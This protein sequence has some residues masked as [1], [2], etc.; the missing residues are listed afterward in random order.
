MSY[1]LLVSVA[2]AE[3]RLRIAKHILDE[4]SRKLH[5]AERELLAY[6]RS[7]KNLHDVKKRNIFQ[8]DGR[9]WLV[10]H[11]F[12]SVTEITEVN[13]VEFSERPNY[14]GWRKVAVLDGDE[15]HLFWE[16]DDD[17]AVEIQWPLSWQKTVSV[18]FLRAQGFEI[19]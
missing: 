17:D 16:N 14:R 4:A 2:K 15:V 13:P 6:A 9:T 8:L 18:E 7:N 12:K 19:E 3:K 5:E 11:D 1:E 10:S